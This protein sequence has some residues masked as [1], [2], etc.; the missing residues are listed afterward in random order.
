MPVLI[1][2]SV[3]RSGLRH[4]EHASVRRPPLDCSGVRE[5]IGSY[6]IA[7]HKG[8]NMMTE[9]PE[10]KSLLIQLIDKL[11]AGHLELRLGQEELKQDIDELK[12]GQTELKYDVSVLK[13]DV[14]EVKQDVSVLK[15]D[16][17]ELKRDVADL[18]RV[19][20]SNHFVVTGRLDEQRGI[21]IDRLAKPLKHA[22]PR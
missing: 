2:A 9:F 19:T 6:F 22:H 3:S 7:R 8:E 14:A 15:S 11:D 4:F 21:V 17:S 12:R 1:A 10:L 18:K 16:V 5:T 13:L 20:G